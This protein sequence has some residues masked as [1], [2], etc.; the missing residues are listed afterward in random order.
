MRRGVD[1]E[2]RD[3]EEEWTGMEGGCAG[4]L[5]MKA[6]MQYDTSGDGKIDFDEYC[7][8]RARE[9]AGFLT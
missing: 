8:V 2:G 9:A 6:V 4:V 5:G 3:Q 1:E 7:V